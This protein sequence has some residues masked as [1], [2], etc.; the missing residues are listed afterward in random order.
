MFAFTKRERLLSR[1]RI[2]PFGSTVEI[3]LDLGVE[4]R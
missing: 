1:A 3:P 2:V 4:R